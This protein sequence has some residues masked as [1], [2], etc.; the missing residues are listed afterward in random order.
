MQQ[1]NGSGPHRRY[2]VGLKL[3]LSGLLVVLLEVRYGRI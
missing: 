3:G 1:H 2:I